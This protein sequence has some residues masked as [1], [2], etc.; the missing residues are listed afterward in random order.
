MRTINAFALLSF[1]ILLS[2]GCTVTQQVADTQF[3][4]PS[5]QYRVI[6]MQPA[7]SVGVLTAG[8]MVEQRQDWTDQ[9][10]A[11]V[12]AALNQ[13]QLQRGGDITI[14]K[15]QVE[16]GGNPDEVADLIFL[17]N[18]VG[19]AI[20][21]HKYAGLALP[22]K[23]G[24]FDWTLGTEAVDYGQQTRYDYA[25]FV[26]AADSFS[27]GGRVALQAVAMI[28]CAFGVCAMPTGGQQFAYASLV[29]LKT[30]QVVWFNTLASSVGD[31]RTAEGAKKMVDGLL[32]T[33]KPGK[34]QVA[35]KT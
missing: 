29:D 8:G 27:S 35:N 15:T 18:V 6:V 3:R 20:K 21:T 14:A 28:G 5:G 12:L 7:I 31:I 23:S 13:Q 11:N 1:S 4:P 9:A 19:E 26:R 10:R 33:M 25:L 34:A 22:T 32:S 16:A 24:K 17:H 2:S 30:G